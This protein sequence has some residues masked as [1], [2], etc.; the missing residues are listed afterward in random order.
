MRKEETRRRGVALLVVMGVLALLALLATSFATLA[1]VERATSRNHLDQVRARLLAQSGV[2]EALARLSQI[3]SGPGFI[4]DRSWRGGEAPSFALKGAVAVRGRRIGLSG[5]HL[6][7]TYAL[8]GD[9]YTLRVTDAN[10]RINVNDGLAWGSDHSVSRNLRRLL[11]VLGMQPTVAVPALGDRLIAA[12]P[13]GGYLHQADLLRALGF[14]RAAYARVRDLL[15]V[16]SWSDPQVANPVPLSDSSLHHYPVSF[17]RPDG[18]Y[19]YGHQK[20]A[21]GRRIDAPLLPFDFAHGSPG[22]HAVWG[23]DSLHPQWIEIVARSPVNVNAA[24]REVLVALLVDL[25][26]FF[27]VERR[28][29]VPGGYAWAS[30]RYSYDPSGDEGDE[31]GF[32]YRTLPIAGP[33]GRNGQ[34]V[35]AEA[36]ADEILAGREGRVSPAIPDLDYGRAPFGGPFRS[37]GQFNRFVDHLVRGGVIADRRA[38]LFRDLGPAGTRAASPIQLRVASQAIADV[39]KAN[40][41]PN[42]H[43]NEANP[44]RNLFAH[45]DKT[46][47]LV[48]S[49]ELCFTPMGV[50][51][52]ES[53]GRV[54]RPR[55]GDD[56][57][58]AA[59]NDLVAAHRVVT[60]VRLF[61][62]L[63]ETAQA[64]FYAGEI[65]DRKG[66]IE[67]N[68]NRS[69]ETGPEPDNGPAPSEN[70]YEGYLQ[71]ATYGG[72]LF[73]PGAHKPPNA[74]WA[75]LPDPSLFPGAGTSGE[76][77]GP[78]LGSS[79]HAHFQLDHAA[80]SHANRSPFTRPPRFDGFLL[81]QGAWTTVFG[82]RCCINRNFEDRTETLA[83]PYGPVDG[84]R[85]GMPGRYRIARSFSLLEGVPEAFEAA[86][87][88]LRLDGAY[89]ERHSA[90]G[91]WL[92]ENVSWNFNEGTAAFWIKPGFFPEMTGK[93]RTFL[94][95]SRYHAHAPESM[96]PSP[97]ALFFIPGGGADLSHP[98]Y[99]GG[100]GG[101]LPG[102]LAFGFGFSSPHGYSWEMGGPPAAS[103]A[104]AFTPTLNH[105]GHGP[106]NGDPR[107]GDDGRFNHLRAHEWT[108]LAVTWSN[109]IGRLP[110]ADT[111]RIY[112]NGRLLPNTVGMPH[113]YAGPRGEG[114]PFEKTPRWHLHSLQTLLPGAAKPKWCV[115]AIRLGGEPSD[116]F[117]GVSGIG[118][119]PRN[120]S[121]DATFDEFYLWLDRSTRSSGGLAGARLLASRGRYYRP[122]DGDPEDALFTSR[123]IR[124]PGPP[125]RGPERKRLIAVSWTE[126]AEEEEGVMFDYGHTP[127]APLRPAGGTVVDLAGIVDGAVF[128]PFRDPSWSP[129]RTPEGAPPE[130]GEIR[131]RAK[132]KAGVASRDAV[133]LSP[134]VLADITLFFDHGRPEILSRV[135]EEE[136]KW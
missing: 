117:D 28:R 81:P 6:S 69:L 123:A 122:D 53:E 40:F 45:V 130:A 80:H 49:T 119:F 22:H 16:A 106:D 120:F 91:Y 47:L 2:E 83:P 95:A 74:L 54:V 19:R 59:E 134:P 136:M 109:P 105:E 9:F 8:H 52:I 56:A 61:D 73:S 39:L 46:D 33:G 20:D 126:L 125:A 82:G 29:P 68:N 50:F 48:H 10:S 84:G 128:G 24:R 76:P 3:A 27:L 104:F 85:A 103:H 34:G 30:V 42:L 129:V 111:A 75:T 132:L 101:F 90:F 37:W 78:H 94:S 35:S 64:E 14:D 58:A 25:E 121:A 112:V 15:T 63:R 113:L 62:A 88:D 38:D 32:L 43:L 67:T 66:P 36:I 100:A 116:L 97:F 131:Y 124:L 110:T 7:G 55:D 108:H 98:S 118:P 65:S 87:G 102:A 71:L 89:V 4:D 70:R 72:N 96:N 77:G 135:V 21:R 57:L 115:N 44:N 86:P 92:E 5:A 51:E 13:R 93:S 79:I 99:S 107:V 11:N 127:P 17:W 12:R 60:A 26:G 18:I 114:Q 41:N 1:R 133:L 23:R 31:C